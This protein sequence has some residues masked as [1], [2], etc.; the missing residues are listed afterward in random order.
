SVT[1]NSQKSKYI[2]K[3]NEESCDAISVITFANNFGGSYE[4]FFADVISVSDG[5]I[6]V[7]SSDSEDGDLENQNIG[8]GDGI[9]VKYNLTGD[10]V[11]K[12]NFGGSYSDYFFS[13]IEVSDGYVVVG[14]SDSD[15]GDLSGLS[16]GNTDAIIVKYDFNGD[17]DW[18]KTYGGTSYDY[19][20]DIAA[21]SDGYVIVGQ[22]RSNNGIFYEMNNGQYDAVIVKTDFDGN[23]DWVN[24]YGGSDYESFNRVSVMNDNYTVVG[25]SYSTDMEWTNKGSSDGI[26]VQY[27]SDGYIIWE[28][29]FGGTSGDYLNGIVSVSDGHLVSGDSCSDDE[30]LEGLYKG[31]CD[32]V[33]AK[34]DIDGNLDWV[35][36]YGG[37]WN[38]SF[39]D[40]VKVTDGYVIVGSSDSK[41]DDLSGLNKGRT[42]GIIV[43]YDL[44]GNVIWKKNYGGNDSDWFSSVAVAADGGYVTIGTSE[45]ND[46]HLRGQNKGD[47]DAIIYKL[48]ELGEINKI[49]ISDPALPPKEM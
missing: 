42:D 24:T 4:D 49:C 45:S 21:T 8:W 33:I 17:I 16:I 36:T 32:G 7:G 14:A 12:K 5:Y 31:E 39:Y 23:L 48:D 37:S 27:D 15:D 10:L 20:H 44:N 2:Y 28:Q 38:D 46:C 25:Y 47:N 1:Y 13:I 18:V 41:D 34:Y 43:K 40:I 9:I 3:Y 35:K 19:F 11:W 29:N 30:D 22:T 26:L 6:A